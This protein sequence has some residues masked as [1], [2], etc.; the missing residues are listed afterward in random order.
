MRG[1]QLATLIRGM[2]DAQ[3]KQLKS[4]V[5]VGPGNEL[6]ADALQAL[7]DRLLPRPPPEFDDNG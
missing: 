5:Y 2:T 6:T 1:R 3:A 4:L 7:R